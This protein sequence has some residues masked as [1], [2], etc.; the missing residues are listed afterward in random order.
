M[1][2]TAISH[3]AT[4]LAGLLISSFLVTQALAGYPVLD[5]DCDDLPQVAVGTVKDTCLGLVADD[6]MLP[7]KKP[8][9]ALQP[10]ASPYI[11]VTDM[12]GWGANQGILWLLEFTG[13]GF[14]ELKQAHRLAE[15][16]MLPHEIKQDPQGWI[17]IGE[18]DRIWRF[19][20]HG[21]NIG[22]RQQVINDLPYDAKTYRHPLTSFVFMADN[23]LLINVGSA[24]DDCGLTAGQYDQPECAEASWVGLRRYPY[25]SQE[26]RWSQQY[27]QYA[28]G[29]R[30]SVA[31]V[32][33]PSGT[34]LQ[35][36]NSSDIKD[37]DEPYEEINV[38]KKG[39]FYGWPYCLN[40]HFDQQFIKAGCEQKNYQPPYSLMPP[41]TA[42]LG[43]MYYHGDKLPQ[44]DGKLLVSW[45]GYR[46]VGNRLVAYD[47]DDEGLPILQNHDDN[48]IWFM[49]D[50][51]APATQFTRHIANPRGGS[52]ADAQ[53]QEI[54]SHWNHVE[55]VRPEG[56][57][58]GLTQLEDESLLI[59]D[60]KNKA[61]LRLSTGVSYTDAGKDKVEAVKVVSDLSEYD[62][63]GAAKELLLREC[64][65]C[66]Q[67]LSST[68]ALVLNRHTGWLRKEQGKTLLE[69][70]LRGLAGQMPPDGKLADDQIEQLL[71]AILGR[72]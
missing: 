67:E 24:S 27:E 59:V 39:G 55:G 40:R 33:H 60:D 16:L 53:H 9:K 11:L 58:V 6:T 45:H 12:G 63:S 28:T 57:P 72:L 19:K 46:V 31:L 3:I 14:A 37:A 10:A 68:P 48:P 50:P 35:G 71:Q 21:T 44:L 62:F 56:A 7:F 2:R 29:L 66:H 15:G 65:A 5:S 32:A 20:L 23:S 61:L 30:N 49:R 8:R 64:A 1:T 51:I 69:L 47:V 18:A 4:S 26:K 41:H 17:Y 70:K 36:E 43:M 54:I 34:L 42:P 52:Y 22:Q 25:I 13:E 38:V